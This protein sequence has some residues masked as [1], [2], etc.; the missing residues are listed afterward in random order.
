MGIIKARSGLI[1]PTLTKVRVSVGETTQLSSTASAFVGE[2]PSTNNHPIPCIYE[3]SIPAWVY[4]LSSNSRKA[5]YIGHTNHL[6]NRVQQH[7]RQNKRG[8]TSKYQCFNLVYFERCETKLA[9]FRRERQLKN[10]QRSWKDKLIETYNP[11][12]HN[13][14]CQLPA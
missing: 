8:F 7:I 10:W 12:W 13:L 9:A 6:P 11:N 14:T 1:M 5:L 2:V 4:M 3:K